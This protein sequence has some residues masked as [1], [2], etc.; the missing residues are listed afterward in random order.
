MSSVSAVVFFA[1]CVLFVV[2][3]GDGSLNK[4]CQVAR[5]GA[6]GICRYLDDCPVV[7][8]DIFEHS[9]YP[10]ECG[11]HNHKQII[12]CPLPPTTKPVTEPPQ[13][14]RIG[15]K[16]KKKT[17]FPSGLKRVQSNILRI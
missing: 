6:P 11:S 17:Q 15:S 8:V 9:L 7:L 16:S 2:I 5:T 12:C 4:L 1:K 13:P 10:V 3:A 14:I